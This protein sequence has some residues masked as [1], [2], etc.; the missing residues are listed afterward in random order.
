[1]SWDFARY[2]LPALVYAVA[3]F[4]VSCLSRIPLPSINIEFQDKILHFLA[5]AGFS[6]LIYRA[7]AMPRPVLRH[8]YLAAAALGMLY[9]VSDEFHQHFVQGRTA[10]LADLTADILGIVLV[11]VLLWAWHSR[12]RR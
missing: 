3:L 8:V 11:Q 12:Q 6:I 10:E 4:W 9:A 5:Y 2:R 1:M 7:L